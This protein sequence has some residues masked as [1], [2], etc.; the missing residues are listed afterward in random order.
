MPLSLTCPHCQARMTLP[1]ETQVAPVLCRQCGRSIA[2]ATSRPTDEV[3]E[4]RPV[5]EERL[6]SGPGA[7]P[8]PRPSPAPAMPPKPPAPQPAP[9][10]RGLQVVLA[11]LLAFGSLACCGVA[12]LGAGFFY[13][14]KSSTADS[15]VFVT[16]RELFGVVPPGLSSPTRS[17]SIKR[18]RGAGT[19]NHGRGRSGWKARRTSDSHSLSTVLAS[20]TSGLHGRCPTGRHEC[21]DIHA[22]PSG[23]R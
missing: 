12:S 6:Q 14:M 3:L 18:S 1:V 4:A 15:F 22:A 23:L 21:I 16:E 7:L 9:S 8:P 11:L 5:K 10:N 2:P 20:G 19:A 13:W 17:A